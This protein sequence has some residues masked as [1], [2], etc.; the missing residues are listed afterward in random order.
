M[1]LMSEV[2]CHRTLHAICKMC[3]HPCHVHGRVAG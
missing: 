1:R 2:P 3:H